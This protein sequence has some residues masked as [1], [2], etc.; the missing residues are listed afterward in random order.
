[1]TPERFDRLRQALAER[2]HDLTVLADGVHKAHNVSAIIRTCDAAGIARMHVVSEDEDFRRHHMIAGGSKRWVGVERHETVAEAFG[3]LRASGLR[4]L[5]AH[6]GAAATDFRAV[7]YKLPTAIVVGSEL[8]GPSPYAVD[9]AD[10]SIAIPMHGLVES[11][12]VSVAAAIV[13]YEAERQRSAA[14]LYAR[15]P[16]DPVAFDKT[17]FE[18]AHPKI[19]RRCHE[20]GVDYPPLAVDGTLEFNPFDS[21]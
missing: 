21:P 8:E 9:N 16:P 14:G 6:V 2:Q 13:L 15:P 1:M 17:L 7:D 19:A 11:L 3:S 10:G 5:T 4:I 20:L 18:W 12:N